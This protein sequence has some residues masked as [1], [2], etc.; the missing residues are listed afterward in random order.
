MCASLFLFSSTQ[1]R[2]G[3]RRESQPLCLEDEKLG[4]PNDVHFLCDVNTFFEIEIVEIMWNDGE[5]WYFRLDLSL[6]GL[7]MT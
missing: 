7:F 6:N 2:K 4:M 3:G 5:C 1:I